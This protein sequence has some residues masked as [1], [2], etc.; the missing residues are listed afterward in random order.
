MVGEV[1]LALEIEHPVLEDANT[2]DQRAL[3]AFELGDPLAVGFREA[4]ER[5]QH[6]RLDVAERLLE[7]IELVAHLGAQHSDLLAQILPHVGDIL[8]HCR[9][10]LPQDSDFLAQILPHV[11]DFLPHCG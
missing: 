3:V 2:C 1:D 9:D 10:I 4:V 11:S 8:P 7:V 6:L 5:L